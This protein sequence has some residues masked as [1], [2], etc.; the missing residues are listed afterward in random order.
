MFCTFDGIQLFAH[1]LLGYEGRHLQLTRPTRTEGGIR[2]VHSMPEGASGLGYIT[3]Q[4]GDLRASKPLCTSHRPTWMK[5]QTR[6]RRDNNKI[7]FL[8]TKIKVK[9]IAMELNKRCAIFT[10]AIDVQRLQ[11]FAY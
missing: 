3:T 11:T 5:L 4:T 1:Q 6:T 7:K 8:S 10:S 9:S 2:L